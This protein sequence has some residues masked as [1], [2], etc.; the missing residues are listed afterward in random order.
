MIF[1]KS[2]PVIITNKTN[3]TPGYF[4]HFKIVLYL[5]ALCYFQSINLETISNL[6]KS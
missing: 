1:F 6:T 3:N 5:I 4:I 2:K